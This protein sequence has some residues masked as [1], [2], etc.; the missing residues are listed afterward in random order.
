[1]I[2]FR[3]PNRI[4]IARPTQAG[5]TFFFN[6]ILEHQLLQP[7]NSRVSYVIDEHAPD[8]ADLK[9]LYPTIEYLQ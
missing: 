3:Q 4:L 2:I 8:L 5:K 6:Q 7:L 1:M 9:H